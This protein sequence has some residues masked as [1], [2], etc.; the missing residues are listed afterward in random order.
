MKSTH[1]F[2]TTILVTFIFAVS[3]GTAAA[4]PPG[5]LI[6]K[7]PA[8]YGWNLGFNLSIDG[9]PVGSLVQGRGYQTWLPAGQHVLTV[10]K[11]PYTGISGP[12]STIVNVQPGWTYL[13]TAM[14]DSSFVFLRPNGS[15][16]TPGEEWQNGWPTRWSRIAAID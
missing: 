9:R 6:V 7:R 4:Q 11:V 12:T 14:W 2:A 16:L 1:N 5:R 10:F 13:Y 15:W 3:I 8:N